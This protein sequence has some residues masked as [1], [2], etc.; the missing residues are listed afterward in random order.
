VL[1]NGLPGPTIKHKRGLRQVDPLSPYVFILA[2]DILQD[3]FKIAT[4]EGCLSTLRGR[5]AKLILSLYA[6]DAVIF[7]N[8]I[9]SDVDMVIDIMKKF[10]DATGL[11]INLQ[12]SSVA[13]IPVRT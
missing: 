10:G 3:L 6:D 1:L 5:H 12:K 9:K 11:R 2:I 7:L 8:P 4:E 13:S